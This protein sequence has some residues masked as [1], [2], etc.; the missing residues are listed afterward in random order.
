MFKWQR[1][2]PALK[3]GQGNFNKRLRKI[4]PLTKSAKRTLTH[5]FKTWKKNKETSVFITVQ[6]QIESW[7][8]V[9]IKRKYSGGGIGGVRWM[10]GSSQQLQIKLGPGF[11]VHTSSFLL[12]HREI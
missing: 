3:T 5:Y 8:T 11:V 10:E 2:H 4:P 1:A 6:W 7:K 12:W 9:K